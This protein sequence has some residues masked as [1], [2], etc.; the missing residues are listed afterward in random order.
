LRR[1]RQEAFDRRHAHR[2]ECAAAV[3]TQQAAHERI[4]GSDSYDIVILPVNLQ[5]VV[6]L[7]AER[8]HEFVA[9]LMRLV[10]EVFTE[11][12]ERGAT[13]PNTDEEQARLGAMLGV[14]CTTCLGRCCLN[15]NTH[16][17]VDGPTIRRY[18]IDN[19]GVTPEEVLES[20][21]RFLPERTFRGG[22][23]FQTAEGCSLPRA[24]RSY[25]CNSARC[26]GLNELRDLILR[27]R[28]ERFYLAA[29]R[30]ERVARGRFVEW[31]R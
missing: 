30:G 1:E 3:R 25:T 28:K 9:R 4:D 12:P 21:R 13:D 18:L 11:G 8:R 16:A 22:C 7:P 20:Y 2:L 19:P 26:A 10:D 31:V 14:A 29:M 24:L 15:G 23:V 5:P 6:P 17:F 27:C